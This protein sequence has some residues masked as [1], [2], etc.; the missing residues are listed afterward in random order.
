MNI[1][2]AKKEPYDPENPYHI[3]YDIDWEQEL[4]TVD[5]RDQS[6][7]NAKQVWCRGCGIEYPIDEYIAM[8]KSGECY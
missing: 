7:I 8:I 2:Y 6:L 3:S 4:P 5:Y 1:V